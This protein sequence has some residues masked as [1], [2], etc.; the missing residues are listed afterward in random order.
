MIATRKP[1]IPTAS[2]TK[3][4]IDG[5]SALPA[6]LGKKLR[7]VLAQA[8]TQPAPQRLEELVAALAAKERGEG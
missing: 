1:E 4:R 2:D 8:E 3:G 6:Q 7:E 5:A